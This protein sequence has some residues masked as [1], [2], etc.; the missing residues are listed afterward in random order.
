[1]YSELYLPEEMI[2][3]SDLF[4]QVQ[5]TEHSVK[6]LGGEHKKHSKRVL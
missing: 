2:T 1:M 3:P 4:G 6:D 5:H